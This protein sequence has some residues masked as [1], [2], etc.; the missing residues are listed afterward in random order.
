ME[1]VMPILMGSVLLYGL[2][3]KVAVFDAFVVGAKEGMKILYDIAPTLIALIVGVSML[4]SSGVMGAFCEFLSPL[5]EKIGF[6][7]ELLPMTLL[8][9]VSGG[10]STAL[11]SDVL[12]NYGPDSFIGRCA[13]VI[14][15]STET[16]FYAISVYFSAVNIKKIR[17]TLFA[18]LMADFTAAVLGVLSVNLFFSR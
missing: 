17:H 1:Y 14:A 16:T 4:K 10:S 3:R 13:S 9:P 15:G 6:P 12:K 18:S 11:L 8:R 7:K 2:M 5:C